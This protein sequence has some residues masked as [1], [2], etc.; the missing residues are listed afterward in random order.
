MSI[1]KRL[2][3]SKIPVVLLNSCELTAY[4]MGYSVYKESSSPCLGDKLD[5][6]MEPSNTMDYMQL[7]F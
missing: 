7:L 1:D 2:N 5:A 3:C 4:A 6:V